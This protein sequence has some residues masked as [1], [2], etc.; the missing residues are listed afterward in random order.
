ML[1]SD[2]RSRAW[3]EVDLL[4]L[5]SNIAEIDG[6]IGHRASIM[7]VI[8]A[9]AYGHG[10]I[11]TAQEVIEAGVAWLGIATVSEGAL[12]RE[13][14]ISAPIA[15]LSAPAEGD[16]QDIVRLGLTAMV[17]DAAILDALNAH[18]YLSESELAVHLDI[19]TGMGRSGVLPQNAV[20]LWQHARSLGIAVDGISTHYS[21]AGNSDCSHTLQQLC[22]FEQSC[23]ALHT[24]GARFSW[25]HIDNS[26]SIM[27]LKLSVTQFSQFP[28]SSVAT[29]KL[30]LDPSRLTNIRHCSKMRLPGMADSGAPGVIP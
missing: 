6:Y 2:S 28:R 10:L 9:D 23:S 13:A 1:H 20:S 26:A 4:A 12:L 21:D 24:A 27:F 19:D 29:R 14:N 22:E 18:R 15:L 16:A 11:R 7:A 25:T 30:Q 5:H 3:V 8:K 17:G